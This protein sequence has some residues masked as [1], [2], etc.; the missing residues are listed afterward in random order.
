M[1]FLQRSLMA[2]LMTYF[3]LLAILPLAAIGYIAYDSGRQSTVTNIEH[4]LE[5]VAILKQQEMEN[6]VEHLEHTVIWLAT[7]RQIQSNAAIL[8]T[9]AT[10]A[11]QYPI[12]HDFLVAE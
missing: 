5:S 2:R 4:H 7:S 1:G 3:L 12:A 11:P 6:W 8:A 10:S 9:R